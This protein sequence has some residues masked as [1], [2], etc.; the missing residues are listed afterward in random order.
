MHFPASAFSWT[1][2]GPVDTLVGPTM[3]WETRGECWDGESPSD[4][5]EKRDERTGD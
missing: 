2:E 1:Q 5:K 3:P 4:G